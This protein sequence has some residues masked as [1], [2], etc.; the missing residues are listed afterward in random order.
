MI[1]NNRL[2]EMEDRLAGNNPVLSALQ[3]LPP[4]HKRSIHQLASLYAQA[5]YV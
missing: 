2:K 5:H 1:A 4:L 3:A